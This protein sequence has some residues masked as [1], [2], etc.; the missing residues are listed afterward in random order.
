MSGSQH[1]AVVCVLAGCA[2]SAFGPAFGSQGPRRRGSRGP[3]AKSFH[4]EGDLSGKYQL[5]GL[6]KLERV[7]VDFGAPR[8]VKNEVPIQPSWSGDRWDSP[9]RVRTLHSSVYVTLDSAGGF[10][11]PAG[12]EDGLAVRGKWSCDGAELTMATFGTSRNVLETYEGTYSPPSESTPEGSVRGFMAYGASEPEYAGKFSMTPVMPKLNPIVEN[13]EVS[14]TSPL[15]ACDSFVGAWDLDFQS[16]TSVAAYKLNLYKNRTWETTEGSL[17][18]DDAKLA[19]KWNLFDDSIDL[20]SGI[21]GVG[22]R[23]WLWLRRFGQVATKGVHLNHDRLYIGSVTP[24]SSSKND[25]AADPKPKSAK[26]QVAIGWSTEPAFIGS[27]RMR[28]AFSQLPDEPQADDG[29][30]HVEEGP[31]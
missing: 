14:R 5:S 22:G 27:F 19:G 31:P 12:T 30:A 17:G 29:E 6:W 16:D 9:A 15:F 26:G 23:V 11:T 25:H 24:T 4:A 1:A 21:D 28:P 2:V 7:P 20:T 3:C 8:S 18:V 13:E 10:S